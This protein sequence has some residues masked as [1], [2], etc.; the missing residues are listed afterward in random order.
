MEVSGNP[1][2]VPFPKQLS[3]NNEECQFDKQKMTP[4]PLF[5]KRVR[6]DYLELEGGIGYFG[7]GEDI[8]VGISLSRSI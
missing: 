6:G 4:S 7:G 2:C 1:L 5:V 3:T 8:W